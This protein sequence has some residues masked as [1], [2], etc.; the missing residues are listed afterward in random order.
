MRAP[1]T[2]GTNSL[3]HV[4]LGATRQPLVGI[5]FLLYQVSEWE[6]RHDDI[7]IDV[8]EFVFGWLSASFLLGRA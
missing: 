6:A 1:F 3:A 7:V 4:S 2:D 8:G 5:A